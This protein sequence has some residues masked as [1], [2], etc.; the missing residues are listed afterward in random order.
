MS[1][2]D[3]VY[4]GIILGAGHNSLI[5]QAYLGQ[6][7]LSTLCLERSDKP[8]GGL[9]TV[10]DP[11]HPGFLHNTHSFFHRGV[12]H[13]PWYR[14]LQLEKYGAKYIEPDLNVALV[15]ESGD[16]LGWWTDFEKT[17]DSFAQFS[18][19]DAEALRRW[20]DDFLP[21]VNQI[22]IP[23]SQAPPL[24]PAKRREWLMQSAAGQLLLD[25]SVL[26]PLEF[27]ER[28]FEHP[29]IQAGLLF[30][31][32][33]REVDLRCPGFGHHIPALLASAGK[34]QMCLGGSAG[35]ARA[36]VAAVVKT[37]GEIRVQSQPKE[38]VVENGR[39]VGIVTQEGLR[40]GARQFVASGLNPQQTFLDL[41]PQGVLPKKWRDRALRFEYN[42]IAPLFALNLNLHAPPSYSASE[43]NPEVKDALMVILG[44]EHFDQFADIVTHHKNGTIPPTVMWGACPTHF[45]AS[46]APAGKHTAFMW[47][48]LPYRLNGDPANW[49]RER[50]A[51]GRMMLDRW[52][53]FAPNLKDDV[54]DWFVRSALDTERSLPNMVGGDLLVGAFGN[55]QVGHNRPFAGAGN[56]RGYLDGLYLCGSCCH[57]G[58]NITGL[59]GYNAAQVILNDLDLVA[60]WMPD[61]LESIMGL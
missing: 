21:V 4:D 49:D 18:K 14:D 35:L 6:I 42:M 34:A 38:M 55:G 13:L 40:I 50:E 19:N 7:G 2:F 22:L 5:L 9:S 36:L 54:V 16:M 31:N 10:E 56:Y 57:P 53:D 61:P 45:D 15:L 23:E 43:K 33:L 58:G 39:V 1:E 27:V 48:K 37:G 28:E 29:V 25:V 20:R 8:G 30:F 59:P 32:G 51:H 3:V 44:L 52:C 60:D 12:T 11:R 47:E 41:L 26:S 46:Q 24:P 17:V